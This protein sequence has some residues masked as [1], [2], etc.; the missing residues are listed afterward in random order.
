MSAAPD[1]TLSMLVELGD[2]ATLQR[3][4]ESG[5]YLL[6]K[7]ADPGNAR[8]GMGST[9]LHKLVSSQLFRNRQLEARNIALLRLLLA[10]G[11]HALSL[12]TPAL[13]LFCCWAKPTLVNSA[14]VSPLRIAPPG[15]AR[16][17]MT[18]A[19]ERATVV[20]ARSA[21]PR[22]IGSQG[23]NKLKLETQHNVAIELPAGREEAEVEVTIYAATSEA[24][25][26]VRGLV[27][28]AAARACEEDA[29]KADYQ[30]R[31]GE[32]DTVVELDVPRER[33]G[34]VIGRAGATLK[35]IRDKYDV[36]IDVPK[37]DE[38]ESRIKVRG[39][40]ENVQDA[41][42]EIMKVASGPSRDNAVGFFQRGP[43]QPRGVP[44]SAPAAA[45]SPDAEAAAAPASGAPASPSPSGGST[46]PPAP[47]QGERGQQQQ[48][49]R[50]P[51]KPRQQ[52]QQQQQQKPRQP[53]QAQKQQQAQQ[54]GAASAAVEAQ[55]K[56]KGRVFH[57][58]PKA[59][60]QE[61]FEFKLPE[62]ER[63]AP[64]P[65]RDWGAEMEE[66]DAKAKARTKAASGSSSPAQQQQQQHREQ[67]AEK[68]EQ[69]EQSEV[70]QEHAEEAHEDAAEA[71]PAEEPAAETEERAEAS[72]EQ[73]Q[74]QQQQGEEAAEEAAK[75]EQAQGEEQ[76]AEAQEAEQA[77]E[78]PAEN[79]RE[80]LEKENERMRREIEELRRQLT[81]KQQ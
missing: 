48:R 52:Q 10:K 67:Q 75:E 2:F 33:H 8:N 1:K 72:A 30:R 18:D 12:Q 36:V 63:P 15:E 5:A 16:K 34:A 38:V 47:Q 81:Q 44:A 3:L 28:A 27:E 62:H 39:K 69:T 4:L 17:V 50:P 65:R 80:S 58:M 46:P 71:A 45:A 79:K 61:L 51:R 25:A 29:K 23:K 70:A 31:R 37:R 55:Q 14:G 19:C 24:A 78:Q 77:E 21:I 57:K 60:M 42:E 76:P 41:A 11:T 40:R 64:R 32:D 59:Q 66:V 9:P 73:Q 20:V 56:Q 49:Q 13:S 6:E 53:Q 26:E 68:P 7:G 22:L 74:Q 35:A 43:R 54:G